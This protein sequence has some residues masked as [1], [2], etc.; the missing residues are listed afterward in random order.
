MGAPQQSRTVNSP[1]FLTGSLRAEDSM[2][3][4]TKIR[5][6]TQLSTFQCG[7]RYIGGG[8]VDAA[9]VR[10]VSS[11]ILTFPTEKIS[12]TGGATVTE[13]WL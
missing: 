9:T 6:A 1:L 13:E 8:K 4:G 3:T 5:I 2:E 11:E 12:T 7:I 10:K